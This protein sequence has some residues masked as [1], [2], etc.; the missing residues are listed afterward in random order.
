MSSEQDQPSEGELTPEATL[1]KIWRV[2]TEGNREVRRE[3]GFYNLDAII[4]VGYRVNSVE[5]VHPAGGVLGLSLKRYLAGSEF[6][7]SEISSRRGEIWA[8]AG[9]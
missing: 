7:D 3:I 8:A 9:M 5:I 6:G 1:R 2:Q 4:S